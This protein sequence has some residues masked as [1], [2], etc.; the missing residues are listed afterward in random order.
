MFYPYI[1]E[2]N[3]VDLIA[4][5]VLLRMCYI[6]LKR[7][8]GVEVFKTLNVLFCS[9]VVLHFYYAFGELFHS[10]IKPFPVDS[11]SVFSYILLLCIITL[12]FRFLRDGF[13]IFF[14]SETIGKPSKIAGCITGV[15]RGIIIN[16]LIAYGLLISNNHYLDLSTRTSVLDSK[17]VKVPIKIYESS[18][19]EI[20]VRIFPDQAVNNKI[21]EVLERKPKTKNTVQ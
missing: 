17:F 13:F 11:A 2:F 12:I 6:G 7:G 19:Q 18:L 3:W 15:L 21:T 8:F 4:I 9:F 16:G 20:A 10:I 5:S 14:K 1:S